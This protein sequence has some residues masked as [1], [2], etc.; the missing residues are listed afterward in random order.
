M[1]GREEGL[2]RSSRGSGS[3]S[4]IYLLCIAGVADQLAEIGICSSCR[5][6]HRLVGYCASVVSTAH[7]EGG[8]ST[9]SQG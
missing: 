2:P 4:F 7:G 8:R 3:Y 6:S 1:G 5:R 9:I